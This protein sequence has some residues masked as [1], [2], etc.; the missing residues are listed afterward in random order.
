MSIKNKLY[1]TIFF[2]LICFTVFASYPSL[3]DEMNLEENTLDIPNTIEN[4]L[5][6]E[7]SNNV[8]DED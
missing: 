3:G 6:L 2:L 1:K 5:T 7:T 8:T 4:A